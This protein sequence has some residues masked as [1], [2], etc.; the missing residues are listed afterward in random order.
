[1]RHRLGSISSAFLIVAPDRSRRVSKVELTRSRV[2]AANPK[3]L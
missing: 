1:V 3:M 2:V